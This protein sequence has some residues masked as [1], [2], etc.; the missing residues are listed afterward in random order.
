[1]VGDTVNGPTWA[2][3]QLYPTIGGGVGVNP[4]TFT[5]DLDVVMDVEVGVRGW[6]DGGFRLLSTPNFVRVIMYF[7]FFFS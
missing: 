1:M 5:D 7:T 4:T 3:S 2:T 6:K